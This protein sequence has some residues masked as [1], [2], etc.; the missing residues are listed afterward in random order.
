[1][2]P[3]NRLLLII[4]ILFII[5]VAY[6]V[7]YAKDLIKNNPFADKH[8]LNL[9]HK[10][11]RMLYEYLTINTVHLFSEQLVV[12]RKTFSCIKTHKRVG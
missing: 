2:S 1:M 8:L 9:G 3:I 6:G 5:A 12:D 10:P 7:Y 11:I 4:G